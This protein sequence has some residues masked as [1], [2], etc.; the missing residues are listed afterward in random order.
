MLAIVLAIISALP[1]I[2]RSEKCIGM[3]G[4]IAVSD[5]GPRYSIRKTPPKTSFI[6]IFM[7]TDAHRIIGVS[8]CPTFDF[9]KKNMF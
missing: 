9:E 1:L 6:Y 2:A 5:C 8:I 3:A 7:C 4:A